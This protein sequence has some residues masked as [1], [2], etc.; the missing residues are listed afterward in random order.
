MQSILGAELSD[1]Y[2]YI[3]IYIYISVCVRV[4]T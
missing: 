4:Y 3:Y 2:I 1:I